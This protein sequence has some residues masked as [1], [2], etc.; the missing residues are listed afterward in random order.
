MGL[1][2]G[3]RKHGDWR[4]EPATGGIVPTGPSR[5]QTGLIT[6]SERSGNTATKTDG[7]IGMKTKVF[8]RDD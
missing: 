1:N 5:F 6:S 8:R 7:S 4:D 2:R 3:T